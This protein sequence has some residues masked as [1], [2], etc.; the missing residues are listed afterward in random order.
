MTLGLQGRFLLMLC[1]VSLLQ[2]VLLSGA[3]YYYVSEQGEIMSEQKSCNVLT[4]QTDSAQFRLVLFIWRVSLVYFARKT[5][6]KNV[7][8]LALARLVRQ[9]SAPDLFSFDTTK[10]H[11]GRD[12]ERF[13]TNKDRFDPAISL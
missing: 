13:L 9:P 2:L 5:S 3:S 7:H 6:S 1:L 11:P 8:D 4:K 10:P 12:C